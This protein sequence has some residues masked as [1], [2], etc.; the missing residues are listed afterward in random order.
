MVVREDYRSSAILVAFCQRLLPRGW[1]GFCGRVNG[2]Q[3]GYFGSDWIRLARSR[4]RAVQSLTRRRCFG[5]PGIGTKGSC[6]ACMWRSRRIACTFDN[7]QNNSMGSVPGPLTGDP[8]GLHTIP[9][10]IS[11]ILTAT[12]VGAASLWAQPADSSATT[13]WWEITQE[14]VPYVIVVAVA[15]L[16]FVMG[17]LLRPLLT[18]SGNALLRWAQRW[19]KAGSFRQRYLNDVVGQYRHL[20]L[21]LTN[22]VAASWKHPR[23]VSLEDLYTPLSLGPRDGGGARPHPGLRGGLDLTR[24][25]ARG[26]LSGLPATAAPGGVADIRGYRGDYRESDSPCHTG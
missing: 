18:S 13:T 21:L 4:I 6:T 19:G 23:A 15:V 9:L 2:C 16:A 25:T 5:S 17:G 26:P 12:A 22:V 7:C 14:K 11:V 10:P 8:T 1:T 3:A 24:R 20:A